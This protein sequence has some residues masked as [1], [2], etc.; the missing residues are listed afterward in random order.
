MDKTLDNYRYIETRNTFRAECDD[1]ENKYKSEYRKRDYVKKRQKE[2]NKTLKEKYRQ[3]KKKAGYRNI[4]FNLTIDEFKY[5]TRNKNCYLCND[6]HNILGI[7]RIDS[8]L[9]YEKI[10]CQSCCFRCNAAKNDLSLT[11]F[12]KHIE[13]IIKN[14]SKY[15]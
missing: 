8:K 7:D 1:C 12:Y 11:D 15:I 6:F 4:E 9:C 3:T 5:L 13:K 14:K 2:Y 10:N